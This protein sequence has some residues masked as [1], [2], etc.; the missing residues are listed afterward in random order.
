MAACPAR[1]ADAPDGLGRGCN[2]RWSARAAGRPH[3][4]GWC[5]AVD[6]LARPGHPG[7]S[8]TGQCLLHGLS[9][10]AAA[11]ARTALA[12]AGTALAAL[13]AEQVAGGGLTRRVS[14]GL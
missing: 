2:P 7:L 10:Y 11:H 9:V 3:E 8:C 6:S 13:V 5:A 1:S 12:P 14:L 4:P